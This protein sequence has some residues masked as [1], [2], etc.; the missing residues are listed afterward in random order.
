MHI[1]VCLSYNGIFKGSSS[2]FSQKHPRPL[3]PEYPASQECSLS[4][5]GSL[6]SDQFLII[7]NS[8]LH[9]AGLKFAKTRT[10]PKSSGYPECK[11]NPSWWAATNLYSKC[12]MVQSL[13]SRLK[14]I[15]RPVWLLVG[16]ILRS[17]ISVHICKSKPC[18]TFQARLNS[19][20]HL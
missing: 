15:F 5:R 7:F 8:C 19:A 10:D 1:C 17:P 18:L 11:R 9:E 4:H 20:Q 3:S 14:L 6:S 13:Y 12:S 2:H 16:Q